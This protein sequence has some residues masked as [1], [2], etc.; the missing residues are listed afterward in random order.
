MRLE[1]EQAGI[2]GTRQ[3]VARATT[4]GNTAGVLP[5]VVRVSA[6]TSEGTGVIVDS[7]GLVLTNAHVVSERRGL[8]V[9]LRDGRTL[10]GT[11]QRYDE[12][13][14]LALLRVQESGLPQATLG[15]ADLLSG[16]EPLVAIGYAFGISGEPT[17]TSGVF[18]GLRTGP[19]VD[20]VQTDA[21]LN[22]GNSGG[23]LVSQRG[24]VIGINTIRVERLGGQAV[25]GV[26]FAISSNSVK[27]FLAGTTGSAASPAPES[28]QAALRS[29]YQLVDARDFRAAYGL[30][31]V[32]LRSQTD[33]PTFAS[34]F[35]NKQA[36]SAENIE[37][38][39]RSDKAER[40]R[41]T[42]LSTDWLRG[43]SGPLT[44]ARYRETWDLV[45]EDGWRL[46]TRV[47]T[48]RIGS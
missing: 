1:S 20:Y 8:E 4:Q 23:P 32:N 7:A 3:A 13:A 40:V 14:D 30:L 18:S 29:Y 41:A 2:L 27:T 24:E 21:A 33:L 16:G 39:E 15:D 48:V 12:E 37:S 25:Q 44:T 43:R 42:V 10:A 5:S 46:D 9:Q 31:S 17:I 45:Y 47:E 36:F 11:L 28:A 6:L 35:E 26:N 19:R 34:W 38:V 22:P